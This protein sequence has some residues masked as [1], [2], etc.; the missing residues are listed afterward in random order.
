MQ[1]RSYSFQLKS[2][3]KI[4]MVKIMFCL[5]YFDYNNMAE[6]WRQRTEKLVS[7]LIK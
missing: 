1:N 4:K 5:L 7:E 3:N 6:K 2:G